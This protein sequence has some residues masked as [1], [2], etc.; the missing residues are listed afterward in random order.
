MRFVCLLFLFVSLTVF[1]Q[2][3]GISNNI[4]VNSNSAPVQVQQPEEKEEAAPPSTFKETGKKLK[5]QSTESQDSQVIAQRFFSVYNQSVHHTDS[6]SA[7]AI[8][9]SELEKN[10]GYFVANSP[11]SFEASFFVWLAGRYNIAYVKSLEKAYSMKP[12]DKQVLQQ[13]AAAS[14]IQ[15]KT[16][17]LKKVLEKLKSIDGIT[18]AQVYYGADLLQTIPQNG[19]L[20]VHGFS[21]FQAVSYN[22]LVKGFRN[23]VTIVSLDFLQSRAYREQLSGKVEIPAQSTIDVEFFRQLVKMNPA[24]PVIYSATIPSDYFE[25]L[26]SNLFVR[27]LGF[28]YSRTNIDFGLENARNFKK[29]NLWNVKNCKSSAAFLGSNYLPFLISARSYCDQQGETDSSQKISAEIDS[30]KSATN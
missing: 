21:D 22:Q 11:K 5:A 10:A 24:L 9:A 29:M 28:A 27:G 3:T 14:F 17:E 4:N 1:G 26:K 19:F 7:T 12:S 15:S 13:V 23:D 8:E 30:L 6:R 20:V 2:N 16:A 25:P 18:D